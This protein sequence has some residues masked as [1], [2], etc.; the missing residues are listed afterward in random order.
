MFISS[1]GVRINADENGALNILRKVSPNKACESVQT[2]RS[3]GQVDWPIKLQ[4]A[5]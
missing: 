2:L 1:K 5:T 4:I 3:R